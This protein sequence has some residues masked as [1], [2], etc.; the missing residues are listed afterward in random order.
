V[1]ENLLPFLSDDDE[2]D[3][4]D[5]EKS[6]KKKKKTKRAPPTPHERRVAKLS[7]I[8]DDMRSIAGGPRAGL[9]SEIAGGIDAMLASYP[10]DLPADK[11]AEGALDALKESVLFL[12]KNDRIAEIPPR[13]DAI[14]AA[15]ERSRYHD[16]ALSKGQKHRIGDLFGARGKA[17]RAAGDA[18]GAA[19]D[20]EKAIEFREVCHYVDAVDLYLGP[21]AR[22][23]DVLRLA[24]H[25]FTCP[26][27]WSSEY[28]DPLSELDYAYLLA[29]RERAGGPPAGD[30]IARWYPDQRAAVDQR[31]R[32]IAE[33]P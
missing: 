4:D 27:N 26:F 16:L 2:D 30:V 33:A 21:L 9:A 1:V 23:A 29:A 12:E 3:D 6:K 14:L 18:R 32:A 10:E 25:A 7:P 24:E 5:D 20:F 8:L 22:P 13:V 17:R 19:A 28:F 15:H 31:L 11:P